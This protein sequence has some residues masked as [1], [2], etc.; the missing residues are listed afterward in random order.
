MFCT[1]DED[2]EMSWNQNKKSGLNNIDMSSA[3]AA[4]EFTELDQPLWTE[5]ILISISILYLAS[6]DSWLYD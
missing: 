6:G 2:Y 5:M 1:T 4:Y 3:D